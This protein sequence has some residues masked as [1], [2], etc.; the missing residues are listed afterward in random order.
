MIYHRNSLY[1]LDIQKTFKKLVE[2][3]KKV[4]RLVMDNL[5]THFTGGAEA[6]NGTPDGADDGVERRKRKQS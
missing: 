1:S 3:R 5:R 2:F 4:L 6:H